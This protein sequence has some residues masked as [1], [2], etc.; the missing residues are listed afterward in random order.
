ML[1]TFIDH[2]EL[3]EIESEASLSAQRS[4]WED[5]SHGMTSGVWKHKGDVAYI[6]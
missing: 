1:P 4:E 6:K 5:Q 3:H 2:I